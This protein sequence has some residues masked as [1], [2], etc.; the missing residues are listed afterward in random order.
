MKKTLLDAF[1]SYKR[2][3]KEN[4]NIINLGAAFEISMRAKAKTDFMKGIENGVWIRDLN[5][6]RM[7]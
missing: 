3:S 4:K 5:N 6:L 2:I 1:F 7:I